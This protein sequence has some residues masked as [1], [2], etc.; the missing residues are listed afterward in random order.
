MKKL[1]FFLICLIA[2]IQTEE[3]E[4]LAFYFYFGDAGAPG[5]N[6]VHIGN[7]AIVM[8]LE[9]I[10]L[11][12][13]G[14]EYCAI[15]FTKFWTENTS[16]VSTL[17][18]AAGSDEYA[19]YELYYQGDKTGDFSKK[20]VL[21]K[22]GKLSHTKPRGIGRLA[23]SFG[24][25]E[26]KC[27][28]IKLQWSGEGSVHFYRVGQRM[29]DYGIELAPTKWTDISQVNVFDPRLKWYRYDENRKRVNIPIDKLWIDGENKK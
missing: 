14:A 21:F 4:V 19:M 5:P 22:K 25:D 1:L 24:N 29:G 18:V 7:T 13:K 2:Y 20:N 11:V 8:P 28:S 3:R 9:K 17:F 12:R 23:F 6:E 16:E 10:L 27:G 15:K 26:I